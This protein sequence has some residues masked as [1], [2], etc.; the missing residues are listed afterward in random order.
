MP[1][2]LEWLQPPQTA[3]L[4]SDCLPVGPSPAHST[5]RASAKPM[6]EQVAPDVCC[7]ATCLD[8]A[9]FSWSTDVSCIA[10]S[11][12]PSNAWSIPQAETE[13]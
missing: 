13:S 3:E 7:Q 10:A 5:F 2:C 8:H 12:C 4:V 9:V 6:V 11:D 1:T